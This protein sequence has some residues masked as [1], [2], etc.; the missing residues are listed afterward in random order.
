MG[1]PRELGNGG[2]RCPRVT[3]GDSEAVRGCAALAVPMQRVRSP[4]RPPSGLW[5]HNICPRS[6]PSPIATPIHPPSHPHPNIPI[7]HR[8]NN[9]NY[10][11]ARA[12]YRH[13]RSKQASK[14][15]R[16][17]RDS[18]YQQPIQLNPPP[19]IK[20]PSTF[21]PLIILLQEKGL[22]TYLST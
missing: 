4:S 18:L 3:R 10:T 11:H 2:G 22:P 17:E 14:Q 15:P 21:I 7:D 9:N 8:N 19:L 6:L 13:N 20:F 1:T 5:S 16:T 12:R